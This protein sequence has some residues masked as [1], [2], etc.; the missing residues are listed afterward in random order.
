MKTCSECDYYDEESAT[1]YQ[2]GEWDGYP[3]DDD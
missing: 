2:A 3:E 1:I